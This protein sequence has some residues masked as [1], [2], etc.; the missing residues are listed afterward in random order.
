MVATLAHKTPHGHR[1]P[2]LHFFA[3]I[4]KDQ[5]SPDVVASYLF[6][7]EFKSF[8]KASIGWRHSVC[9]TETTKRPQQ[10][11]ATEIEID[12]KIEE[13]KQL[14]R[15]HEN[16][17]VQGH[18][19]QPD[20]EHNGYQMQ[21]ERGNRRKMIPCRYE[22][23]R[24]GSCPHGLSCMFKHDFIQG[25]NKRNA[26][27]Q[28]R[29]QWWQQGYCFGLMMG[30]CQRRDCQFLHPGNSMQTSQQQENYG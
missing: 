2:S 13:M 25:F 8:Q 28:Q 19:T 21:Q 11:A 18:K 9:G 27:N 24:K 1:S 3:A 26:M 12:K 30:M 6:E 14:R 17:A 4:I 7:N 20:Q 29:D 22:E 5:N 10:R 23:E 15:H 16:Y